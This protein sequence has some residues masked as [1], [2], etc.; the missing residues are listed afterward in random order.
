MEFER[1]QASLR[2]AC[3]NRKPNGPSDAPASL[4]PFSNARCSVARKPT[5]A[6]QRQLL[7]STLSALATL[8]TD[9]APQAQVEMRFE[10]Y[11]DAGAHVY[12][13]PPRDM[14]AEGVE[15]LELTIGERCNELLPE[16]GLFIVSA[17]SGWWQCRVTDI[18]WVLRTARQAFERLSQRGRLNILTTRVPR[19]SM[20]EH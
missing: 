18:A 6:S 16:T 7:E 19:R 13:H 12:V 4:C 5:T 15:R 10:Q 17:V 2:L 14:P 11:E 20:V 8:I 3:A 1:V 9:L